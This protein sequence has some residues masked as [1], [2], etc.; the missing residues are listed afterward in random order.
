[1]VLRAAAI[2]PLALL[3]LHLAAAAAEAPTIT[4]HGTLSGWH[5]RRRRHNAY[6]NGTSIVTY[7]HADRAAAA[8]AAAASSSSSSSSRVMSPSVFG[9][10]DTAANTMT[11]DAPEGFYGRRLQ[12]ITQNG[13]Q[14]WEVGMY[15]DDRGQCH[16]NDNPCIMG[17]YWLT[18]IFPIRTP[19]EPTNT[20][21]SAGT[22]DERQQRTHHHPPL[23]PLRS[24]L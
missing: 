15:P 1:M 22:N 20:F 10:N 17:N 5:G 21:T 18:T 2:V 9:S 16:S 24:S 3:L 11:S 13:V 14:P 6:G 12:L 7:T 19:S 8:A 23:S 4:Q